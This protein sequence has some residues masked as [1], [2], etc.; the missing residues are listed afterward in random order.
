MDFLRDTVAEL[1]AQVRGAALSAR[2]VVGH[3][4]HRIERLDG[5]VNAFTA[6]DGDAALAAAAALDERVARG[7]EVGPLAGIPLAV[8]DLEDAAGFVTSKGSAAF[9]DDPPAS[10]DSALVERLKAAGCI[11]VGKTNTPELGWKADT[12]NPTFGATRNPLAPDRSP[13]GSSGGSA[14]ALAAG[15]VPLATGSDG[16]GSI[17]IPASLCGL[18]GFKPSLGRVPTGGAHA[19]DWHHLSTRGVMARRLDDTVL[20]LDAVIGPD[21]CDLRS[22]PMPEPA[23]SAALENA[24]APVRVAW[25]PTL[26]YAEVDAEVRSVCERAVGVLSDLGT[27]VVEVDAVFPEDPVWPWL[28]L[29]T[30]YNLRTL[31][32]FRHTPVW[33]RVDPDLAAWLEQAAT[34]SGV[35]VVRAEDRCHEL[36]VRLVQLFHDVRLLV[37]PTVA[38]QAPT[39]GGF[40]TVNGVAT[41]AWVSFTYPFNLTRSPAGTIVAGRAGDGM[42]VGLQLIGPQ[43]GDLVVLRAMGAL[44][45]ALESLD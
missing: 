19:P 30:T 33:E 38:G 21:P 10:A 12:D 18:P 11:V 24:H 17:R 41:P 5:E 4:L 34:L 28:A 40:G 25:S 1:A 20:A 44:S 6:V 45:A 36:N 22:L 32:P 42:P 15:M 37:T 39:S 31:A 16:G 43:H 7:E 2:E 26:G 23:W 29:T 35:D 27:E 3:A 13:G 8:K 9:A 14:A